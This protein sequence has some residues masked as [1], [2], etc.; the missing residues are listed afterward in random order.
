MTKNIPFKKDVLFKTKVA[1]IEQIHLKEQINHRV[2]GSIS[3][4]FSI[5]GTYKMHMASRLS[6]EFDFTMPFDIALD[7][8]HDPEGI[9]IRVTNFRYEI[10]DNEILRVFIDVELDGLTE[11]PVEPVTSVEST[12]P[13]AEGQTTPVEQFEDLTLEKMRT[14]KA[15]SEFEEE[16]EVDSTINIENEIN[17]N[18]ETKDEDSEE[19]ANITNEVNTI[20]N[21]LNETEETYSTYNVYTMKEQD[22][23]E[24]V[25]NKHQTDLDILARYNQ[26]DE[27]K[28][29]DKLIFPI[30]YEDV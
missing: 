16:I 2:P 9:S 26:L 3:G 17:I 18:I 30:K 19:E 23:L 11:N 25:I 1:E 21:N 10:I 6:E 29:G 20:F 12:P 15:L 8:R 14:E 7:D 28:P 5:N 27:V 4:E 22:S 24:T 13:D